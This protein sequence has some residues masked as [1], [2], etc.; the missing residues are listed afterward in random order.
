MRRIA[1]SRLL[2]V[3]LCCLVAAGCAS[4]AELMSLSKRV[5][6]AGYTAV[7]V[8]HNTTNGFDAVTI[9]AEN[10]SEPDDDGLTIARLVWETYPDEVDQLVV[11]VNGESRSATNRELEQLFGAR[12][13]APGSDGG[14]NVGA[15][16]AVVLGVGL[17]GVIVLLIV[18]SRR[19][20]RRRIE[21]SRQP[22]HPAM[23][24]PMTPPP[25][26]MTPP[27]YQAPEDKR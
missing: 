26:P 2:V 1:D 16:V 14:S 3:L 11:A 19:G 21:E 15:V 27:P 9:S 25:H 12:K 23:P 7:S 24:Y 13:I 4:L 18:L 20:R 8:N 6:D 22:P 10:A 5:E 17:L